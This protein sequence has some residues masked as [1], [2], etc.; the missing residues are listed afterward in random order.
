MT[1]SHRTYKRKLYLSQSTH[2]HKKILRPKAFQIVC[3]R[4]AATTSSQDDLYLLLKAPPVLIL[5]GIRSFD[6]Y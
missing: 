6:S 4:D 1:S 5:P 2:H 3:E